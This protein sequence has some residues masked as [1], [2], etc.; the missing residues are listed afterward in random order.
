MAF[1][2]WFVHDPDSERIAAELTAAGSSVCPHDRNPCIARCGVQTERKGTRHEW[3]V[4]GLGHD[5]KRWT[6]WHVWYTDCGPWTAIPYAARLEWLEAVEEQS[7]VKKLYVHA[8][9]EIRFAKDTQ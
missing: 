3:L 2:D 4:K 1:R 9:I 5:G 7:Q 6:H 8:S